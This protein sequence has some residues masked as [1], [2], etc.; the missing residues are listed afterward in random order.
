MVHALA[1]AVIFEDSFEGNVIDTKKWYYWTEG[2]VSQHDGKLWFNLPSANWGWIISQYYDLTG[3]SIQVEITDFN[4]DGNVTLYIFEESDAKNS[5]SLGKNRG[6]WLVTRTVNWNPVQI[7][8]RG[9]WN[10]A[11]GTL[12]IKL[13]DSEIIFYEDGIERYKEK[14]Q[15]PTKRLRVAILSA[16]WVGTGT[17]AVDNF[18]AWIESPWKQ[19]ERQVSTMVKA[20]TD[21][22]VSALVLL[23]AMSL[24]VSIIQSISK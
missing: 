8:A 6:E 2:I 18:K 7:V 3:A 19:A 5:Y 10:K 21:T 20:A 22:T 11:T 9:P 14:Y 12:K 24:L 17:S 4:I 16:T 23:I 13:T 15:L 1:D